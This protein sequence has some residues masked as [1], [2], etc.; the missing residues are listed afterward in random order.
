MQTGTVSALEN[1]DTHSPFVLATQTIRLLPNSYGIFISRFC[2]TIVNIRQRS[3]NVQECFS[4]ERWLLSRIERRT[5]RFG[6]K[7]WL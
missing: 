3:Q 2:V 4:S 5:K 6:H 7:T 1:G